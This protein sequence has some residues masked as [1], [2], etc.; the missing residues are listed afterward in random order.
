MRI[1]RSILAA[2][3]CFGLAATPALARAA[4]VTKPAPVAQTETKMA[5]PDCPGMKAAHEQH[6][7]A[8]HK[9]CPDCDKR[10]ACDQ[11]ACQLKCFKVVAD[12]PRRDRDIAVSY[13]H[14]DAVESTLAVPID[15]EPQT[16]PPRS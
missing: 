9:N 15:W 10:A 13:Q 2:L 1:F 16:P 5:M 4:F 14:F 11:D 7:P 12:L 3:L 6:K 8:Q